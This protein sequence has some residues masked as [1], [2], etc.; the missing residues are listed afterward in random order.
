MRMARVLLAA[1]AAVVLLVGGPP[2]AF[3]ASPTQAGVVGLAQAPTAP[4]VDLQPP[5][6][7]AERD[8]AKNKIVVG[9][10]AVVLLGIVIY[11]NR[12]RAKRRKG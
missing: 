10:V 12:V 11:G 7:E 9:V 6:T 4:G 3:A 2:A 8:K 5:P 1:V